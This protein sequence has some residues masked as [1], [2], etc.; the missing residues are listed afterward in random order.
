M[1]NRI[2]VIGNVKAPLQL[3]SQTAYYGLANNPTTNTLYVGNQDFNVLYAE[4][5]TKNA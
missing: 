5:N 3:D 2:S 1:M 4:R